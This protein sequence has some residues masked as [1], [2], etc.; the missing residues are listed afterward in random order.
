MALPIAAIASAILPLINKVIP[1][2]DAANKLA[3]EVATKAGDRLHE[4]N[5]GQLEINK[6]EAKHTSLF[7]AGWRPGIAWVCVIAF[8]WHYVIQPILLFIIVL[9]GLTLP[10]LPVFDMDAMLTVLLGL[11]GLGGMRSYEKRHGVSRETLPIKHK[12][13][14]VEEFVDAWE[15]N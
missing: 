5:K 10:E 15:E 4:I 7:V 14:K 13:K 8:A 1:D 9:F 6:E 3:H 2:K 11:L 12:K